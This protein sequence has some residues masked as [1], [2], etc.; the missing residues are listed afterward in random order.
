MASGAAIAIPT[1]GTSPVN[2]L[3]E[4]ADFKRRLHQAI[5]EFQ[6]QSAGNAPRDF[7]GAQA[8]DP[9]EHVTRRHLID[10]MLSALGWDIHRMSCELVEE[11]RARGETTLFIDYLG[12]NP[13]SRIP[14]MIFE[15]KAWAK[16]FVMASAAGAEE[17]GQ[18]NTNTRAA[19]LAAAVQYCK[20][21]TPPQHSPVTAEWTEWISA[22]RNYVV[23]IHANSGHIVNRVAISSG[24]WLVVFTDPEAIFI[25][26][27]EVPPESHPGFRQ[28]PVDLGIG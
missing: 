11:A 10:P 5:A 7:V 17:Q 22:L 28:S 12:I 13:E 1:A 21:D 24:Q 27:G 9:L 25:K 23:T 19:L 18:R 6:R 2:W 8:A 16:P 4:K 15:A 26:P 20:S 14:R 3:K